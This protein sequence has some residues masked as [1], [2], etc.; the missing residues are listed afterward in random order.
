MFHAPA[1]HLT[2]SHRSRGTKSQQ[3]APDE[4]LCFKIRLL[5]MIE[6]HKVAP[7]ILTSRLVAYNWNTVAKVKEMMSRFLQQKQDRVNCIL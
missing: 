3:L 7:I 6:P 4:G 2:D 5:L 1:D